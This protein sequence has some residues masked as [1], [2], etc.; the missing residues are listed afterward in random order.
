MTGAYEHLLNLNRRLCLYN[1]KN[2][3]LSPDSL[4]KNI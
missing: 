1:I 2:L 4:N 3:N